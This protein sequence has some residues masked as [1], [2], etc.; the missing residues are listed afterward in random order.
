MNNRS[1][2]QEYLANKVRSGYLFWSTW[3]KFWNFVFAALKVGKFVRFFNTHQ[4][5]IFRIRYKNWMDNV[6]DL[7]FAIWPKL[8]KIKCSWKFNGLQY[9]WEIQIQIITAKILKRRIGPLRFTIINFN[10]APTP[11]NHSNDLSDPVISNCRTTRSFSPI[12]VDNDGHVQWQVGVVWDFGNADQ[13]FATC[14][15]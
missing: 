3:A 11:S 13:T 12:T 5:Y 4:V 9:N 8:T 14:L 1:S 2:I 10:Q 15:S 6:L 7:K